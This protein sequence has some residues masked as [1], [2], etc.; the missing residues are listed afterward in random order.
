LG[1]FGAPEVTGKPNASDLREGKR[2]LLI[3]RAFEAADPAD[4][5]VLRAGL[6]KRDLGEAEAAALREVLVR[7]GAARSCH[8]DAERLCSEALRALDGAPFPAPVAQALREIA[9]YSV[10]RAA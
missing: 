8:E 7:S 1:T 2:T 9:A 3:A 5:A 6:G 4:A 10:R